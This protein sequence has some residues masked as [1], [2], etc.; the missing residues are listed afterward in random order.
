[1]KTRH[2]KIQ[3]YRFTNKHGEWSIIAA[4]DE[5]SARILYQE[6]N[7]VSDAQYEKRK[8]KTETVSLGYRIVSPYHEKPVP[9]GAVLKL[10]KFF[11]RCIADSEDVR[12]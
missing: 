7:K 8:I 3:A 2:G 1:M 10:V 11:P 5:I 12:T 6:E 9:V 4:E